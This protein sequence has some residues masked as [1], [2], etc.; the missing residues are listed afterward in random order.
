[1]CVYRTGI[2]CSGPKPAASLQLG[3]SCSVGKEDDE[4][5]NQMA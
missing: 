2:N 5:D 4:L 3:N 1:M